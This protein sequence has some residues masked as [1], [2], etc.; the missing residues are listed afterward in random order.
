MIIE[1][2][3][4]ELC[5][6]SE[7]TQQKKKKK[8]NDEELLVPFPRSKVDRDK[9]WNDC[10]WFLPAPPLSLSSWTS[11]ILSEKG[12]SNEETIY[13]W[14]RENFSFHWRRTKKTKHPVLS[15]KINVKMLV[16]RRKDFLSVLFLFQCRTEYK[17]TKHA[18]FNW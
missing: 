15:E 2:K 12:R 9:C 13:L 16:L 18:E 10:F 4:W 8:R 14:S 11:R 7:N 3:E 5:A 6:S 17:Y 1:W